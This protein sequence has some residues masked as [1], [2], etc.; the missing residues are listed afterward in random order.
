MDLNDFVERRLDM[1]AIITWVRI[2]LWLSLILMLRSSIL[3]CLLVNGALVKC[4]IYFMQR[5]HESG[6]NSILIYKSVSKIRELSLTPLVELEFLTGAWM[7]I[8]SKRG[9][10]TSHKGQ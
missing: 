2:V 4:L 1:Q 10:L 3:L 8:Y 5:H 9:M 7:R 6:G